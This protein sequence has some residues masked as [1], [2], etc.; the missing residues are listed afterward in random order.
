MC[1]WHCRLKDD[2]AA[3]EIKNKALDEEVAT[4]KSTLIAKDRALSRS[5]AEIDTMRE[6]LLQAEGESQPI[7]CGALAFKPILD[8][9]LSIERIKSLKSGT[10][11]LMNRARESKTLEGEK[12]KLQARVQG[13][14]RE[15]DKLHRQLST[16][17]KVG[18]TCVLW[19]DQASVHLG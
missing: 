3:K 5:K 11:E 13:L 10:G 15:A 2:V 1:R 18:F 7:D 19:A 8:L 16:V 6:K 14:G 12:G 17:P 4:L 9:R